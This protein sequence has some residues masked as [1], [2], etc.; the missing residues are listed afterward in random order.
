MA[1]TAP[2]RPVSEWRVIC[3]QTVVV[4]LDAGG[5]TPDHRNLRAKHLYASGVI[6]QEV[7][8]LLSAHERAPGFLA[9]PLL[10]PAPGAAD[11]RLPG[12]RVRSGSGRRH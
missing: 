12:M 2:I 9:G 10:G 7:E 8:R 5:M 11:L 1:R 4:I 6:R 3:P